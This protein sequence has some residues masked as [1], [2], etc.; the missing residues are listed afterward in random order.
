[1]KKIV[2]RSLDSACYTVIEGAVNVA[3][4]ITQKPFDVIL[5]TG[6]TEKG[7]LVAGAAAK[8]LVPCILELGGKSPTIVDE[9]ADIDFT[10]KKIVWG[11]YANAGQVCVAPD[12]VLCHEKHLE[13]LNELMKK[14]IKEFWDEGRNVKDC[15]RVVTEFHTKRLCGMMKD[16]GGQVI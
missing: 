11:R 2:V 9:S 15:G 8:N 6:S 12:Y 1:M 13:K 5:F 3:I 14:Y 4:A 7:K 16:H 10:A